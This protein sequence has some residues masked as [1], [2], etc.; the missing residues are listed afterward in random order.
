MRWPNRKPHTL[1]AG[2]RRAQR[3]LADFSPLI[4]WPRFR[5]KNLNEE[6]E[7]TSAKVAAFACGDDRQALVWLLRTDAR[8]SKGMLRQDA[9]PISPQ[10]RVPG[11]GAG[12]YR[13]T[14]WDT[15]AGA[16]LGATEADGGGDGLSIT[17]PPF[18]AD[19]ALAIQRA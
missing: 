13:I 12:R 17:V 19:V 2:M 8:G 3:A 16:T 4:D 5:R 1:T 15:R 18:A 14:A 6:I 10:V 9:N 11:L 7:V